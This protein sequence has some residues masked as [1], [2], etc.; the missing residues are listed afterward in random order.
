V[1]RCPVSSQLSSNFWKGWKVNDDRLLL[2]GRLELLGDGA[3]CVT[4]SVTR[5]FSG[6]PY[7]VTH[8]TVQFESIDGAL[9]EWFAS[10]IVVVFG[11]FLADNS[12]INHSHRSQLS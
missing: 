11:M 8:V 12:P 9:R 3:Y 2:F 1:L 10:L 4:E 5:T 7:C 6:F